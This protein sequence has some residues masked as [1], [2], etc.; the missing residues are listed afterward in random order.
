[1]TNATIGSTISADSLQIMPNLARD[2]S[3]L[4]VLRG[5]ATG[6]VAGAA[7]DQN[8]YQLD[9]GN[10]SDDMSGTN[11]TA[12][13]SHGFAGSAA[14]DGTPSGVV[15]TTVESIEEFKVGTS[16]QTADFNGASG[17]QVQMVTKRGTGQFH[18]ALYEHYFATNVGAANLWRN[19]HTPS[20]GLAYTPLPSSHRNRFGGSFGGPLLPKLL[21]GK[22]FFFFNYEGYRFPNSTTIS[23]W[24]RVAAR[25]RD[26]V[27]NS[28]GQFVPYNINPPGHGQR[29]S[30]TSRRCSGACDPRL[31]INLV[32]A[33]EQVHAA[34]ERSRPVTRS[35]R[36]AI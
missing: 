9:G 26:W 22:T 16:N 27:Q 17:S 35:T 21:G 23:G 11:Y 29:H 5:R 20:N 30:R 34:A 19:N 25:G 6:N 15:P 12:V 36:R 2:A 18:G 13:P 31:G 10:N 4:S 3:A 24:C 1:M 8:V 14:T 33:W 28:A 7:S 32:S